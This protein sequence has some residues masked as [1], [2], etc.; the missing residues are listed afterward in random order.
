RSGRS[1][2][3]LLMRLSCLSGTKVDRIHPKLGEAGH[4]RPALLGGG[5]QPGGGQQ[6]LKERIRQADRAGG[7]R[8]NELD[9]RARADQ[10]AHVVL[11]LGDGFA[12]GKPV[13]EVHFQLIRNDVSSTPTR[14]LGDGENLS[15]GKAPE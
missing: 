1:A 7:G 3:I 11:R 6:L 10:P 14:S 2:L 4:V 5:W 9:R 15:E 8:V 13:I 12:W